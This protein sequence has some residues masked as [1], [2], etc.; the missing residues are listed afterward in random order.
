VADHGELAHPDHPADDGASVGLDAPPEGAPEGYIL[1]RDEERWWFDFASGVLQRQ[2]DN[3][4]KIDTKVGALIAA[5]GAAM[6]FFLDK[7][8]TIGDVV[9]AGL[10]AVP[11]VLGLNAYRTHSW[12][13]I[14]PREIVAYYGTAPRE[15]RL[16]TMGDI[17]TAYDTNTKPLDDKGISFD[18]SLVWA[19]VISLLTVALR[20]LEVLSPTLKSLMH[21]I[22]T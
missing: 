16:V 9:G 17:A 10:F 3:I 21:P 20:V 7:A 18:R 19:I 6:Y 4:D 5:V 14:G 2:L 15:T 12:L 8:S 1:D 22:G 13:D 11:L